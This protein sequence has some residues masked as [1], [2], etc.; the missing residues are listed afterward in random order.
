ME[1]AAQP[2]LKP[3]KATHSMN[4]S[5]KIKSQTADNKLNKFRI[6]RTISVEF[7]DLLVSDLVASALSGSSEGLLLLLVIGCDLLFF[8]WY[9]LNVLP[10]LVFSLADQCSPRLFD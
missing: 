7:F 3:I 6:W 2:D 10:L 1:S 8:A 5:K 9:L 4:S